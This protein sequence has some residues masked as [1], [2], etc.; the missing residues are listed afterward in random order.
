[1]RRLSTV[2][3]VLA[4]LGVLFGV[5]QPAAA[6]ARVPAAVVASDPG[7]VSVVKVGGLLDPVLADF[8]ERSVAEAERAGRVAVVLQLNSSGSVL[9]RGRLLRLVQRVRDA[10]V[11]VAVWV[12]PSGARALGGASQLAGV[13]DLVGVAPNS[14]L[15]RTGDLVYP[16]A[17]ATPPFRRALPRLASGTIGSTDARR[18]GISKRDAPVIGDFIIDLPGVQTKVVTVGGQSKRQPV[19]TAVFSALPIQDQMLH[20][21]ASPAVAY[22]LFVIG[23]ALIVFELFTAGVGVAGLIGAGAFIGACYG[24]AVLP[25]RP[26][27]VALLVFAMFAFAVDVQTGVPRVWTVIGAVSLGAGSLLLYDGQS[28]SWITLL[29]GIVGIGLFMFAGMP[30]MVR[31][32]FST[33]TIGREWMIGET[34]AA[35][36]D[37]APEGVVR[38]RGALWRARTNR[39]TPIAAGATVRVVEVEGLLLEVEPEEGG[40]KDHRE[41]RQ[42]TSDAGPLLVDGEPLVDGAPN[43]PLT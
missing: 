11:P 7:K 6:R 10:K 16:E 39:A 33:P 22:L 5:A 20:T 35:V 28:L 30:A 3:A 19:S 4:V 8:V 2:G 24:L 1:M 25:T 40:A 38:I 36:A 14:R 29:V 13:A 37:V 42:A 17:W 18:L 31:T 12:G 41:R 26:V 9:S 43:G 15:G 27:G 23:M 32:R 34:G 21:M